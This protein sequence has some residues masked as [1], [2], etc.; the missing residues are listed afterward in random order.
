[1]SVNEYIEELFVL[2]SLYSFAVQQVALGSYIGKIGQT[3]ITFGNGV[4]TVNQTRYDHDAT[5]IL[6]VLEILGYVYEYEKAGLI[7]L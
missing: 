2:K 3:R 7:A 1:M 6:G 4:L 5:E